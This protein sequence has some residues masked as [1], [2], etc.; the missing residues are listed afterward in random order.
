MAVLSSSLP[1]SA[2][3]QIPDPPRSKFGFVPWVHILTCSYRAGH[4]FLWVSMVTSTAFGQHGH[5]VV[6][7]W[8]WFFSFFFLFQYATRHL[9]EAS[10]VC[11]SF[12]MQGEKYCVAVLVTLVVSLKK[13]ERLPPTPPTIRLPCSECFFEW[14]RLVRRK[15]R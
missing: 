3:V 12:H 1:F 8:T 11:T 5:G 7:H 6:L 2:G 14:I 10:R 15:G 4:K 13:N 9:S